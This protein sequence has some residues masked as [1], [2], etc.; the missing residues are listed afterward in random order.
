M[1][2]IKDKTVEISVIIKD[3]IIQKAK[4]ARITQHINI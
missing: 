2:K 4:T 3:S 1:K